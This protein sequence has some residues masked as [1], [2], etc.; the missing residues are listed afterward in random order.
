MKGNVKIL[1]K[2]NGYCGF[3]HLSFSRLYI[4]ASSTRVKICLQSRLLSIRSSVVGGVTPS[5]SLPSRGQQSAEH[6]QPS[7][8]E[9]IEC[10]SR[11]DVLLAHDDPEV[12]PLN[13]GVGKYLFI[14]APGTTSLLAQLTLQPGLPQGVPVDDVLLHSSWSVPVL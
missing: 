9:L 13:K 11:A 5:L 6:D 12:G 8:L 2:D 14:K 7:P 4:S 1:R 3:P 10:T